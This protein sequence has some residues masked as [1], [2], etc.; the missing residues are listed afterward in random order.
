MGLPHEAF[1]RTELSIKPKETVTYWV[2]KLALLPSFWNLRLKKNPIGLG[3]F[4]AWMGKHFR[5]EGNAVILHQSSSDLLRNCLQGVLNQLILLFH[6]CLFELVGSLFCEA[7]HQ[8]WHYG[9]VV[10]F[11]KPL[12]QYSVWGLY[13]DVGGFRKQMREKELKLLLI[14]KKK[15]LNSSSTARLSCFV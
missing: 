7:F 1:H 4:G 14:L 5:S 3:K 12:K 6:W 2:Q 9:N 11:S 13:V 8:V 10:H 15:Q